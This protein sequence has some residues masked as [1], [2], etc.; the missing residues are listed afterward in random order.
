MTVT[1]LSLMQGA[2]PLVLEPSVPDVD[3]I[4]EFQGWHGNATEVS[5]EKLLQGMRSYSYIL[6]PGKD[7]YYCSF[8]DEQ[9]MIQHQ[10][11]NLDKEFVKN[12]EFTFEANKK[13]R[14]GFETEDRCFRAEHLGRLITAMMLC[15]P[16]DA[17]PV[18]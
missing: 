13:F 17:N 12:R 16:R 1:I 14:W 11:F 4:E 2:K 5:A 7:C 9:N 10:E 3:Q 8:V 18:C 6:R 15:G